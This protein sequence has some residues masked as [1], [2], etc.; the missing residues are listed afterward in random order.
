M[1]KK[2]TPAQKEMLE[3]KVIA[4]QMT[5]QQMNEFVEFLKKEHQVGN[6][7]QI[8]RDLSGFEKPEIKKKENVTGKQN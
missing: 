6:D 3:K 8:L 7:W 5:Q 4:N 1:Q 2:F